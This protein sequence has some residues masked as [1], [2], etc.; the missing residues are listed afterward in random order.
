[1]I[2]FS[3]LLQDQW[4]GVLNEKQ[5]R[6]VSQIWESGRH[7]LQLINDILDLA[8]VESGKMELQPCDVRLA[9]L[10][11]DTLGMVREDAR[12]KRLSLDLIVLE[13]LKHR[14]V[15]VDKVKVKQILLNLL[16]NAIKFTPEGGAITVGVQ[17]DEN[18]LRL[19]VTDTGVG[20]KPEDAERIFAAFEQAD[21]SLARHQQG[22]GLGLALS[23]SLAELH[24]GKLSVESEG[25]GKGSTFTL[26]IPLDAVEHDAHAE[27]CSDATGSEPVTHGQQ[28]L[29]G[30]DP[31]RSVILVVEDS[32]S[33]QRLASELLEAA[34]FSV[35]Q[36]STAEEG[37]EMACRHRPAVILMD[38]SLPG[39]DGLAA[40]SSLK[41]DPQ[42]RDIPVVALTAHAMKGD[43]DRALAAGC[44]A[45]L[46]KPIERTAFL[47]TVVRML[48]M[49]GPGAP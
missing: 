18:L 33:D 43:R 6:Y 22:T 12:E 9:D 36:A 10:L 26:E 30:A 8:K 46:P 44:D 29:A 41:R 2:G 49:N 47:S 37:I 19:A 24:G 34:G 11:E 5:L 23:R 7:L 21:S 32:E 35:L 25:E 38:I 15:F 28:S 48:S 14:V 42:T 1:V 27:D 20:V 39:K 40:T 3:E 31:S 45:Y 17:E 13:D 16:S 4:P